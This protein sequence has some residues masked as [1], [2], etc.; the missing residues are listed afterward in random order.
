MSLCLQEI[1]F[2]L[3][4]FEPFDFTNKQAMTDYERH[5]NQQIGIL[6]RTLRRK[7]GLTQKTLGQM[8]GVTYQQIQKYE[9][10]RS[11][12][13]VGKLSIILKNLHF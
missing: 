7:Q 1:Y 5:V 8:L 6:I 10:G 3:D 4:L 11:T 12:I 2:Q 9:A 13:S